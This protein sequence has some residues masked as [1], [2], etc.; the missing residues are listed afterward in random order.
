MLA[1]SNLHL[2]KIASNC[3]AV[4]QALPSS[5]Y[6]KGLKDLDLDVDCPPVQSSVG[7]NWDLSNDTFTSR[8]SNTN[9]PFTHRGV[10]ATVNSLFDP[11]G[12]VAPISIQ[13]KFLLRKV[14][15]NTFNWDE[16]LPAVKE[17]EW[18]TWRDSLQALENF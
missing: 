12:L 13:G 2:H 1:M 16:P 3:P 9:K 17:A 5:E 6:A 14:T 4:M 11:L 18:I 15:H 10:L 8:V 7:L